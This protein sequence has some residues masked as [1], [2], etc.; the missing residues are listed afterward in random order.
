MAMPEP[1]WTLAANVAKKHGL[2]RVARFLR[3][4][5]Y[6]LKERVENLEQDSSATSVAKSAFIELQPLPVN[7]VSECTIELE[8]PR[9]HRMRIHLK[10]APMPD[11]TALSRTLWNM[12]SRLHNGCRGTILRW[13]HRLWRQKRRPIDDASH[14][15]S[16]RNTHRFDRS[17][18][19][20]S[21]QVSMATASGSGKSLGELLARVIE[22]GCDGLEVE[23]K[24]RHEEI[25]AM[26]ANLGFGIGDIKSLNHKAL[27]DRKEIDPGKPEPAG[28]PRI[29]GGDGRPSPG[30]R[31]RS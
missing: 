24:D 27:K 2:A 6:S 25:T 8:H 19:K 7:P 1:L 13:S 10:A 26:K 28:V 18:I 3:L 17:I 4:D 9:G 29:R 15:Q 16:L 20:G 12:K 30:F 11:V 5:Y 31:R 22:L 21:R 23:Y 14:C